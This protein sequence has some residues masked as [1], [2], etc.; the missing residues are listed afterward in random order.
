MDEYQIL[1]RLNEGV[2]KIEEFRKIAL[3]ALE[4]LSSFNDTIFDKEEKINLFNEL[5]PNIETLKIELKSEIDNILKNINKTYLDELANI[6]KERN[7]ILKSLEITIEL[8]KKE[9]E[10]LS[11]LNVQIENQNKH[12]MGVNKEANEY[13]EEYN[14][15]MKNMKNE[16]ET[17]K[18][19]FELKYVYN[20]KRIIFTLITSFVLIGM[21]VGTFISAA[22]MYMYYTRRIFFPN[23]SDTLLLGFML[24]VLGILLVGLL[25][26]IL[27][28]PPIFLKRYKK[29]LSKENN[30]E[31]NK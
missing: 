31:E 5:F 27:I 25:I 20:R 24:T 2:L 29:E 13:F 3:L 1:E 18:E 28:K 19:N 14:L 8:S 11:Q 21:V 23:R 16:L 4:R 12:L 26:I 17:V 7:H 10:K 30:N 9:E 22:Y 15:A 6:S